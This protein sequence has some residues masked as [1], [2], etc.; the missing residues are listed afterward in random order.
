VAS[1][2]PAVMQGFF[3]KQRTL[4]IDVVHRVAVQF[5]SAGLIA[6]IITRSPVCVGATGPSVGATRSA[7]TAAS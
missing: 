2:S 6:R 1:F 5:F 7:P 3:F 4:S